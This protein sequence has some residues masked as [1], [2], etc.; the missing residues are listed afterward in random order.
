MLV[1]NNFG[2][3]RNCKLTSKYPAALVVLEKHMHKQINETRSLL[4]EV[5]VVAIEAEAEDDDF[6]SFNLND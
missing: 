1:T 3:H 6:T 2:I 4:E 5:P